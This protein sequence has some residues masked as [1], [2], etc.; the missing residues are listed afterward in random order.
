MEFTIR[1]WDFPKL[2]VVRHI[3]HFPEFHYETATYSPFVLFYCPLHVLNSGEAVVYAN[4]SLYG[5]ILSYPFSSYGEN[6][7][8][9]VQNIILIGMVWA[10]TSNTSHPVGTQERILVL[11]GFSFYVISVLKYLPNDYRYLLMSSTWPVMLYARGTQVWETFRV[12][13][14]GNLSV[15]TTSMNL[16]GSLIRI[17]TTL[18]ETGDI[19]VLGGYLLSGG[20]SFV[21]FVQYWLYLK[22]TQKVTDELKE[23]VKKKET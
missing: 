17:L 10:F 18:Q 20:L 8:L 6:V 15:V 23:V 21:M 9:L 4:G 14:T 22:N 2:S 1:S 3:L 11:L 16:V 5:Y 13:N 12:K 7:S 19:V